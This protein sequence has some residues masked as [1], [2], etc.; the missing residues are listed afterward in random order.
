MSGQ[1]SSGKLEEMYSLACHLLS[2]N[3]KEFNFTMMS[4]FLSSFWSMSK[5][6]T[7]AFSK[8]RNK[9]RNKI[10]PFIWIFQ[11]LGELLEREIT[12]LCFLFSLPLKNIEGFLLK[13]PSQWPNYNSVMGLSLHI[14]LN[15]RKHWYKSK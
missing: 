11:S 8:S 5:A 12:T 4:T 15:L 1:I 10:E 2:R 9:Y 7:S 13:R 6:M 14:W 3:G